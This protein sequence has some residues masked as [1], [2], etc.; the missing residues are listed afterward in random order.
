MQRT[1]GP[2]AEATHPRGRLRHG[3][4]AAAAGRRESA[5]QAQQSLLAFVAVG[6]HLRK[7]SSRLASAPP[8]S[9]PR[10]RR[11]CSEAQLRQGGSALP[12]P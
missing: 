1:H 6:Q 7:R 12:A 3:C 11:D 8:P 4:S 5:A 2:D 10:A 9:A